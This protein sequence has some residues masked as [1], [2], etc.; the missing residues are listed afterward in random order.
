MN[1]RHSLSM[2][3]A[4]IITMLV[5]SSCGSSR[6]ATAHVQHRSHHKS[7]SVKPT[8]PRK[9]E[10]VAID[11]N[12]PE[13]TKA[14]IAEANTWLG[15]PYK[16]AGNDRDGVDCS[17]FVTQVFLRALDIKLPRTSATQNEYCK[18]LDRSKL[19][20][21][22]LV[23][24]DTKRDRDGRTSHVGLYVGDGN[25]IHASSKRGVI[26]TSIDGPFF[27]DRLLNGG[28]VEALAR[29]SKEMTSARN[30]RP[31][32]K[33]APTPSPKPDPV[34]ETKPTPKP[35][36]TPKPAQASTSKPA[37]P[38]PKPSPATPDISA[39]QARALVLDMLVEEKIDSIYSK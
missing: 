10:K 18:R 35:T 19:T 21:G 20:P 1:L 29:K 23:F 28:R 4:C 22:D 15:V 9:P 16:W 39:E 36:P 3:V 34:Q 2:I 8:T 25:M 17:G 38:A 26:I 27:G 7:E 11:P 13:A 6:K 5:A 12:L 24:F 14:L 30:E 37:A 33:P 32:Q 31:A